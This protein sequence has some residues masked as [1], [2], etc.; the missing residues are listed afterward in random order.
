MATAT[1]TGPIQIEQINAE[2]YVTGAAN[3]F[4]TIQQAVDF[5][6]INHY[7]VGTVIVQERS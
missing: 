6:R 2:F 3:G 4:T 1:H 5:V 7:G